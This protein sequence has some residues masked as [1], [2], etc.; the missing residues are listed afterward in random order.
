MGYFSAITD[1]TSA[2]QIPAASDAQLVAMAQHGDPAAY[3]E[4]CRRHRKMIFRTV[5][6][7]I[8][9]VDDAEDVLQ[10]V[11]L[12]IWEKAPLYDSTRGKP[13]TWVV[14]LARNKAI[15]RLRSTQR[16]H[17]LHSEVEREAQAFD[18]PEESNSA[19]A[20]AAVEKGQLVR[21]A[22][23]KLH[24][25]GTTSLRDAARVFRTVSPGP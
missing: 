1:D 14:T 23:Q 9:N 16:S 19:D 3:A 2:S 12:Q 15:D 17:R 7:I 24:S 22:V 18:P 10:E 6:K 13:L 25:D 5:L 20:L 11:F 8:G 4:L 21:E